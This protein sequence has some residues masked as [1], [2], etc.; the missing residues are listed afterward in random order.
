M[1]K[2]KV[3]LYGS[4]GHQIYNQLQ[5]NPGAELEAVAAWNQ[6]ANGARVYGT[7]EELIADKGVELVSLCS[8]RRADQALDAIKCLHAGKHVY[9]EKPCAFTEQ[10]LD[11]IMA[12]AADTGLEFHEM[13]GTV[14]EQPYRE[15]R[16][17]ILEGAIGEVIQISAQKCYP[18]GDWRPGDEDIDGGL[19]TQVGVYIARFVEHIAGQKIASMDILETKFGNP[20]PASDCRIAVSMQ[21]RLENGGVASGT[22]NYLNPMKERTWGYEIVRVFGKGGIIESNSDGNQARLLRTGEPPL[23]LVL[24][25]P[26]EDYFDLF[27]RKLREGTPMP[28]SLVEE[29]NPTRWVIRTRQR[30]PSART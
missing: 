14:I 9:A 7:L 13:A 11:A 18:W 2:V 28:I 6:P 25:Q 4:N 26:T 16:R 21:M 5:A 17:L 29:L 3:G 22:C 27:I 30:S 1:N 8:P 12:T 24:S 15:M 23:D 10:E 19:G 20:S